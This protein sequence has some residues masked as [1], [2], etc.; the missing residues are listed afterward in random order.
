MPSHRALSPCWLALG[1]IVACAESQLE[2]PPSHESPRGGSGGSPVVSGG[3]GGSIGAGTGGAKS[4]GGAPTG[5]TT[6]GGGSAGSESAGGVGASDAGQGQG[7]EPSGGEGGSEEPPVMD[8]CGTGM[9]NL[10]GGAGGAGGMGDYLFFED[11]ESGDD[12]WE[13]SATSDWSIIQDDDGSMVYANDDLVNQPT[14]AFVSGG[15]WT[16]VV[17]EARVKVTHFGGMS[18]TYFAGP[19][20]R[21]LLENGD[22]SFYAL[23]LRG[24][25][26]SGLVR[27]TQGRRSNIQS[28]DADTSEDT[29]Y[30]LRLEA[31]GTS[32][33]GYLDGE[34]IVDD[35]DSQ[36]TYGSIG[37]CV[38]N[39]EARFDDIR[40]TLP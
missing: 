13:S 5:G 37:V 40:V 8:P 19:C 1:A 4:S 28:G 18:T 36:H 26:G 27:V 16:D 31:V 15:C 23:G 3:S 20:L 33:R 10:P 21:V 2:D 32:L 35:S 34:E 11:F 12:P 7:G 9:N 22:E 14:V 30:D 17:I 29:W 38:Q 39:A 6:S 25:G 24:D